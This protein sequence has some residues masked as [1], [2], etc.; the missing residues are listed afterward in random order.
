MKSKTKIAIC[1]CASLSGVVGVILVYWH[2]S[3]SQ[4]ADSAPVK[5]A[6]ES[7]TS[8][9]PEMHLAVKPVTAVHASDARGAKQ[10]AKTIERAGS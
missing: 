3:Q 7:T 8:P 6:S 2:L 9:R 5:G 4:G 1:V 10:L